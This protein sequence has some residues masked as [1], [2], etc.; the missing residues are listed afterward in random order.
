[1]APEDICKYVLI[2]KFG[3]FNWIVMPFGMKNA[4]NTFSRIMIEVCRTYFDRFLKMFMDDLNVHNLNWEEHLEHL[5]Y[6]LLK[7][8]EVNLQFDPGKCEFAKAS[9]AFLGHVVNRDN[10]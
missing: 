9:L 4:T 10:I 8:R 6:V 2:T 7:L 1:M 3:L 5:H